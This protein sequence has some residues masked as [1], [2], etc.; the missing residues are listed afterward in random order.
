MKGNVYFASGYFTPRLVD[1][2][3]VYTDSTCSFWPRF[4]P[5]RMTAPAGQAKRYQVA[6]LSCALLRTG[7][8]PRCLIAKSSARRF[9]EPLKKW[10][11]EFLPI[12]S[13]ADAP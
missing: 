1:T 3:Y 12:V 10:G 8:R 7:Y 6:E 5:Q 11:Q 4:V 2:E 13:G 9:G